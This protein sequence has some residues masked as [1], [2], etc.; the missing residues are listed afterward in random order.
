MKKLKS[1]T[2]EE[3][4]NIDKE[5][6]DVKV[7]L[8]EDVDEYIEELR[9]SSITWSVDH[10][11]HQARIREGRTWERKNNTLYHD[12]YDTSIEIPESMRI[13]DRSK[14]E[15]ALERMIGKHDAN[16]GITWDT[17]DHYLNEYCL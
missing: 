17:I 1:Y 13:Y 12:F 14:F 15:Y 7:Y 3:L 6:N 10:F 8:K 16:I 9:A 2:V 5:E 11:E 4:F